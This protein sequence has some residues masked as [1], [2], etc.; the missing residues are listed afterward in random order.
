MGWP[1]EDFAAN[2]VKAHRVPADE[3]VSFVGF[4]D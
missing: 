4:D 3:L 1:N 2:D